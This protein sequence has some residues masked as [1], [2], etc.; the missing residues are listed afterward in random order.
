MAFHLKFWSYA[1]LRWLLLAGQWASNLICLIKK[2]C[3]S[4]LFL[5]L[6]F[7]YSWV[8][9]LNFRIYPKYHPFRDLTLTELT[10]R[11]G[12]IVHGVKLRNYKPLIARGR[13][14]TGHPARLHAIHRWCSIIMLREMPLNKVNVHTEHKSFKTKDKFWPRVHYLSL[15]ILYYSC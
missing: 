13:E 10:K 3:W 11:Q 9:W 1:R 15:C 14:A 12:R 4:S 8:K 5:S 2:R 7:V 6:F